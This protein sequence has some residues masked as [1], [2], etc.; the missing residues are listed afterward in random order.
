MRRWIIATLLAGTLAAAGACD[1]K[2]QPTPTAPTPMPTT[3]MVT[4]PSD[5]EPTSLAVTGPDGLMVGATA[6][7]QATITYSDGA[8]RLGEDVGR[9]DD[10]RGGGR[11]MGVAVPGGFRP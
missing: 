11:R 6:Q 10:W 8:E 9:V 7:Y 4:P 5:P 3:P 1:D 2:Q